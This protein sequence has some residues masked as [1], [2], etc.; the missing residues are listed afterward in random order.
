MDKLPSTP[1]WEQ[2]RASFLAS[3]DPAPVLA[4]LSALIEQMTIAAFQASLAAVLNPGVAML[5]VGGFGRRELFPFSDVDVLI[6]IEC[7]DRPL[8]S[9]KSNRH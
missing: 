1:A 4:G 9:P 7:D 2:L 5:A 6:L 8:A 3:A